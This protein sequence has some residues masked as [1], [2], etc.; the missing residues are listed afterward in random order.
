MKFSEYIATTQVFTTATL[1]EAV[2]NQPYVLVALSRAAADNKVSRVRKGLY[3]SKSG[4]FT[5]LD[6]DPYL[7]AQTY[8]ED[9]VFVYHSALELHGVAHSLS[10]RVQFMTTASPLIFEYNGVV[11]QCYKRYEDK[12]TQTLV[13]KAYK[14]IEVT[15][16]EQTLVDCFSNIKRAG[17]AEEVIRS[18]NGFSYLD[19][20]IIINKVQSLPVSAISRI[21]WYLEKNQDRL[22]VSTEDL[23]K[24]EALVPRKASSHLDPTTKRFSSEGFSARWRLNLPV[25]DEEIEEWLE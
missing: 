14:T 12:D 13:A 2:G 21:G 18:L 1:F 8:C 11:Y 4:Q 10:S 25:S 19:I 17:G 6:A 23:A 22:E 15:T 3:V 7:I 16:R 9:G 24:L 5:G 20:E